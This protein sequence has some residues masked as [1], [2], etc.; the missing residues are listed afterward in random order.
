MDGT[1]TP[2]G[3]KLGAPDFTMPAVMKVPDER[4]IGYITKG[5]GL[6]PSFK[7]SLKQDEIRNLVAYLRDFKKKK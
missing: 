1:G 5:S 6:M 7:D 3:K 4:L 2:I